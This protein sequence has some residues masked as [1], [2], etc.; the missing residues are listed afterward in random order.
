MKAFDR[1]VGLTGIVTCFKSGNRRL[2]YGDG[3]RV[4]DCWIRSEPYLD[5]VEMLE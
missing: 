4:D 3:V 2:W 1:L 5:I